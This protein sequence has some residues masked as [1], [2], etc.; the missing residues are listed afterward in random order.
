MEQ[1]LVLEDY[2]RELIFE[3]SSKTTNEMLKSIQSIYTKIYLEF[4]FFILTLFYNTL[5]N[6]LFQSETLLYK[7]KSEV[8]RLLKNIVSNY[9]VLN[10]VKSLRNI[11]KMDETN[12]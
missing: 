7:L 4:L 6:I 3:Y 5:F 2:P 1:Y 9:M 11:F 10:Y 12:F 8:E